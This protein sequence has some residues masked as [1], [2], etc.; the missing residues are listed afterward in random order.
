[1]TADTGGAPL[2]APRSTAD[3]A[4]A[5]AGVCAAATAVHAAVNARLLPRPG[6]PL[7]AH[8]RISV[9][10]PARN[11]ADTLPH[12]LGAVRHCDPPAAEILVYDDTSR[13]ATAEVVRRR[14]AVDSRVR[15]IP[16]AGEPPAGWLG[17]P[18]ACAQLAAAATGELLVFCDADTRLGVDALGAV[19]AWLRDGSRSLVSPYP[20]VRAQGAGARL[21]QPLLWWSWLSFVPLRHAARRGYPSLAVAGGQFLAADRAAY[22]AVGGHAAVRD[23][24]IEDVELA[25]AFKRAGFVAEVVDGSDLA[26]CEMYQSWTEVRAGYRKSLW[27]AFPSPVAAGGAATALAWLFVAP[28]VRALI[29]AVRRDRRGVATGAAAT[30]AGIA[31]RVV[32]ARRG[33]DRVGDALAHPAGIAALIGLLADSWI[34]RWRGTLQWRRRTLP[35][36]AEPRGDTSCGSR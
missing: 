8:P 7:A 33:G 10:I 2:G 17:K 28:A 9:C 22:D 3:R 12:C 11:E 34:G 16:S 19:G 15:L 36:P 31:G 4:V 14:A 20:R 26:T 21:I 27:A 25:R 6:A 35:P 13:D 32:T 1:V 5:S 23:R 29:S 30:A 18:H 24:V